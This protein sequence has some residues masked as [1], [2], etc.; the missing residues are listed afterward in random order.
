MHVRLTFFFP[1]LALLLV[2][3]AALP[4][5]TSGG[6][7]ATE[8]MANGE[9]VTSLETA[10]ADALIQI[11]K[12]KARGADTDLPAMPENAQTGAC[13]GRLLL[14]AQYIERRANRVVKEASERLEMREART[15]WRE[16]RVLVSE[17]YTKLEV[18]PATYKWVDA[19]TE[20]LPA[21]QRQELL[22]PAQY[23]TREEKVLVTPAEWVW[24]PGRGAIEKIDE[25]TGEILY[26]FEIPATYRRVTRQVLVSPP[27]YRTIDEP[28][29]YETLRKRVVAEAEHTVEVHVPAV[30]KTVKVQ[31]VVSPAHVV[32][33]PVPA[34]YEAYRYREK[35]A[36]EQLA[37]R[38]IPCRQ[39]LE[40]TGLLRRVQQQLNR[41]GFD[42][43]YADGI[44]GKRTQAAI[45]AFQ[46][47]Q[48]LAS[49]R[50]SV[51]TLDALGLAL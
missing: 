6:Q 36:D 28:A 32:R 15:E 41:R 1:A 19:R 5:P 33:V 7:V 34:E 10:L 31:K 20:V 2:S 4:R 48:G 22:R 13:Y 42:A 11:E 3:C 50:L 51:E 38:Q 9:R 8:P 30:Y 23:E 47:Q 17:A 46:L 44:L 37:W 12:L 45:H 27:E 24:R 26:Q 40:D 43:G 49:G 25:E 14:P 18:V 29:V 16:E 21:R 35:V 39:A